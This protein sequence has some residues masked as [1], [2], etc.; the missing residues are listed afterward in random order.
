MSTKMKLPHSG[1]KMLA[2]ARRSITQPHSGWEEAVT[3]YAMKTFGREPDLY[4]DEECRKRVFERPGLS[5]AL[6]MASAGDLDLLLVPSKA[7]IATMPRALSECLSRFDRLGV[8]VHAI[9]AKRDLN[10]GDALIGNDS[11]M[12]GSVTGMLDASKTPGRRL[13]G[14]AKCDLS[15]SSIRVQYYLLNAFSAC[16]YGRSLDDFYC[17]AG[18]RLTWERPGFR[19]L[20]QDVEAGRIGTIVVA[21][22]DRLGRTHL[23]DSEFRR[24]CQQHSVLIESVAEAPLPGI[25]AKP[26]RSLPMW[27][28][29]SDRALHHNRFAWQR[30]ASV[31]QREV[32][33]R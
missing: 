29:A 5:T 9:D 8:R 15:G 22:F 31:R 6:A 28:S 18:G 26:R 27:R 1:R 10:A 17:D 7:A 4:I 23:L 12:L 14:Y 16:T 2:Y 33:R 11:P 24:R 13:V 20:M 19:T 30:L 3:A 32:R 25:V 21:D